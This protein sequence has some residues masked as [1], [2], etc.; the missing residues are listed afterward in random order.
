MREGK[1]SLGHW[2]EYRVSCCHRPRNTARHRFFSTTQA[3]R[4]LS[5][6]ATMPW[7]GW[8]STIRMAAGVTRMSQA[9]QRSRSCK[10]RDRF[11]TAACKVFPAKGFAKDWAYPLGAQHIKPQSAGTAKISQCGEDIDSQDRAHDGFDIVVA[12]AH[13]G[14]VGQAQSNPKPAKP[15]YL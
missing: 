9:S 1:S 14:Q 3:C 13:V 4:Q 8:L 5:R 7:S 11:V 15:G 10:A 2:R 6:N 12:A